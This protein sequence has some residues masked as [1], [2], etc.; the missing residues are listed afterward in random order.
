[1]PDAKKRED[2]LD[3]DKGKETESVK[4]EA[5]EAEAV[6]DEAK[7]AEDVKDEAK[8]AE[9]VKDEAKEAEAFKDEAK[10]AEA[11]KDKAKE[12]ESTED[13]A[14]TAKD[15]EKETEI[16]EDKAKVVRGKET[17]SDEE[18]ISEPRRKTAEKERK[19]RSS[20]SQ[21]GKR[22]ASSGKG[23]TSAGKKD[24]SAGRERPSSGRRKKRRRRA[25][26]RKQTP[27][28]KYFMKISGPIA[29]LLLI[30]STILTGRTV[31]ASRKAA[32]EAAAAQQMQEAAALALETAETSATATPSPAPTMRPR[33]LPI[34]ENVPEQD[35]VGFFTNG[36]A[37]VDGQSVTVL[38]GG[39]NLIHEPIYERARTDNGY[40]FDYLYQNVKSFIESADIATINQEAPLATDLEDPSG[41]PHFNT[42]KEVGQDLFDAGFDVINIGNNH[43][44][45][46]GSQGALVTEQFF[47][48]R[49]I[50]VV[51]FYRSDEDY[52][53]IRIIEKNGIKVAFLSFV[54]MTNLDPDDSDLGYCVSMEDRELVKEQ[55]KEAREQADIVVAHAHWGEEGTTELTDGQVEMA[56]LMVDWGVDIIFGNHPHVIQS[57]VTITREEDSQLCPVIYSMGNFVSAQTHRNQVVSAML[58]VKIARDAN[59][60]ARPQAMGVMPVITHFTQDDRM[61]IV[62]YPLATYSE[63]LAEAHYVN[64]SDGDFSLDYIYGLLNESIPDRYLNRMSSLT[65]S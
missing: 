29:F 48:N 10:E 17:G 36:L 62:L 4:D 44:Y 54:E 56:H 53:N 41:Y 38:C 57:L 40:D 65:S 46:I 30:V 8:V 2:G 39:D 24:A 63:E 3:L 16:A 42:P 45:D 14:E 26:R 19:R 12:T 22:K 9:D 5:K 32:N 13:E 18:K 37:S 64:G 20:A 47:Q 51:G 61:D 34:P 49:G 11:F 58:A 6:K 59:G 60:I 50:P 55:I 28:E 21:A 31:S 35:V 52:H 15:K 27:F 25:V 43:M 1:M 23:S 33:A 7:V